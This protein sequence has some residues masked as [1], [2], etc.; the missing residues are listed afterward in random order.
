MLRLEG[1][2]RAHG[3]MMDTNNGLD[4][5]DPNNNQLKHVD[6]KGREDAGNSRGRRQRHVATTM[7]QTGRLA[8]MMSQADG[9]AN[10]NNNTIQLQDGDFNDQ[11]WQQPQDGTE[12]GCLQ[13]DEGGIAVMDMMTIEDC[14]WHLVVNINGIFNKFDIEDD[15]DVADHP[16]VPQIATGVLNFK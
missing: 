8:W 3:M 1:G 6:D 7:C 10:C 4:I 2:K 12:G 14:C 15:D 11:Q 16:I 5:V 13:R 9:E